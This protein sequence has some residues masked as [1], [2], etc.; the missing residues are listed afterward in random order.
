[1]Q[2]LQNR[3]LTFQQVILTGHQLFEGPQQV[4]ETLLEETAILVAIQVGEQSPRPDDELHY[5]RQVLCRLEE[6]T[7][8]LLLLGRLVRRV[9]WSPVNSVAN[10]N[11][12]DVQEFPERNKIFILLFLF[13]FP[14]LS[15]PTHS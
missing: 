7:L 1:M 4:V 9:S 6:A 15:P 12:N 2:I 13:C 8:D 3:P 11:L 14:P 10:V 5:V